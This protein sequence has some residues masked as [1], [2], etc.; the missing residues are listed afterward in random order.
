M[1]MPPFQE[2]LSAKKVIDD[3]SLNQLVWER[4]IACLEEPGISSP[5]RIL[6]AGAGI[7]SMLERMMGKDILPDNVEFT[8]IDSD[9]ENIRFSLKNLPEWSKKL[10]WQSEQIENGYLLF[11]KSRSIRVEF[12]QMDVFEFL[13]SRKHAQRLDLVVANAFLDLINVADFLLNLYPIMNPE[14]LLYF[15]INYDG[16]TIF[17]PEVDRILDEKITGM[18]NASMD[19]HRAESNFREGSR[20][21]RHLLPRLR[22]SGYEILEAGSSDWVVFAR[23]QDYMPEEVVLIKAIL[24]MVEKESTKSADVDPGEF[25]SWLKT[26]QHQLNKGELVYIAHQLDILAR[27]PGKVA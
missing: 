13:K 17:E 22:E 27:W 19:I 26:R 18:F 24:S 14:C 11:Q 4:L 25:S 21:G 23:N 12:I 3:R 1:K 9:P 10:G 20:T 16:L 6:E 15:S 8:A 5:F 7:G 2:Y